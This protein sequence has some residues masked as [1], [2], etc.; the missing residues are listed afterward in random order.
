LELNVFQ[1]RVHTLTA[2]PLDE[3]LRVCHFS[4]AVKKDRVLRRERNEKH[5]TKFW[6]ELK[7][8]EM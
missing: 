5:T 4:F 3:G 2:A 1:I 8:E 6:W 7:E